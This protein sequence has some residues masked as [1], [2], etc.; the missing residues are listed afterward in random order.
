VLSESQLNVYILS[1]GLSPRLRE[2]LQSQIGA[3]L[4]STPRWALER[5]SNRL[6]ELGAR[7]LPIIVEPHADEPG[8]GRCLSFGRIDGRPAVRLMPLVTGNEI[9]W[10]Q[11]RRYLVARAVAYLAA[12][13]DD[14]AVFWQRWAEAI[15][16]DR[17][18]EA[19]AGAGNEWHASTHLGLFV[20]MCAAYQIKPDH[21][22][23][24]RLP[25]VRSFLEEWP[26]TG[27]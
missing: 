19:A 14:D 26:A 18:R 27:G 25:A 15:E 5:L 4:R 3:T 20:E 8:D 24:R 10:G 2:R 22:R 16:C 17:L 21:A 7:N 13:A 12:P 6:D 1:D 23:W 9:R 11:D